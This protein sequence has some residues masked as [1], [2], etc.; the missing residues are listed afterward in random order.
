MARS[1]HFFTFAFLTST[2]LLLLTILHSI[3]SYGIH[4][5]L[6]ACLCTFSASVSFLVLELLLAREQL[7]LSLATL[8]VSCASTASVC[9]SREEVSVGEGLIRALLDV[10]GPCVHC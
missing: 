8:R 9:Q 3:S 7:T 4:M 2:F 5:P 1:A 10:P 6:I